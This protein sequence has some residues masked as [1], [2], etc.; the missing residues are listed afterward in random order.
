MSVASALQ[1]AYCFATAGQPTAPGTGLKSPAWLEPHGLF[2]GMFSALAV[3]VV[4]IVRALAAD[5]CPVGTHSVAAP[6][7]C[8][9]CRADRDETVGIVR[10]A[11]GESATEIGFDGAKVVRMSRVV[12]TESPELQ[13]ADV[14]SG[15]QVPS[16]VCGLQLML[17][18]PS[19]AGLR[20]A[21]EQGDLL[22]IE[23]FWGVRLRNMRNLYAKSDG[24]FDVVGARR[25]PSPGAHDRGHW[26]DGYY[27]RRTLG[28][29]RVTTQEGMVESGQWAKGEPVGRW[30]VI[31]P[32]GRVAEKG[33]YV[34][35]YPTGQWRCRSEDGTLMKGSYDRGRRRGAW[36]TTAPDGQVSTET[37]RANDEERALRGRHWRGGLLSSGTVPSPCAVRVEQVLAPVASTRVPPGMVEFQIRDE[38]GLAVPGTVVTIGS[39]SPESST[40]AFATGSDGS[41]TLGPLVP[42]SYRV[43]VEKPG[44]EPV[45]SL[46]VIGE[47]G[48][49]V[50]VT[51][52][53]VAY[54]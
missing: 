14:L 26:T 4:F 54:W 42:G 22:L 19:R 8:E 13:V 2:C 32:G 40:T 41:A 36:V 51:I 17:P 25:Y 46:I 11:E 7:Y 20:W 9:V 45:K 52:T 16:E 10:V 12:G 23:Q 24:T 1:S 5:S 47:V 50:Q 43:S 6:K 49:E 34:R 27:H 29:W 39:P 28:K 18:A 31:A 15:R 48:I 44:F 53:Y 21:D 37:Y 38:G 30:T 33:R 35:G 3:L